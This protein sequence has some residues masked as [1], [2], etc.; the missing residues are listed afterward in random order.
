MVLAVVVG[1]GRDGECVRGGGHG[2]ENRRGGGGGG[3]GV[4]GR[5]FRTHPCCVLSLLSGLTPQRYILELGGAGPGG[6]GG[7]VLEMSDP[8]CP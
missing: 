2:G 1:S 8:G 5:D 4:V 6:D 7:G 3:A